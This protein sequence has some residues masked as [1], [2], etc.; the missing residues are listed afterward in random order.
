MQFGDTRCRRLAP[1]F[2]STFLTKSNVMKALVFRAASSSLL[3][4]IYILNV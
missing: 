1:P 2:L 4:Y 3:I